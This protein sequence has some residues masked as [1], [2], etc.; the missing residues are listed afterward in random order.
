MTISINKEILLQKL[1]F[2]S[3]FTSSKLSSLTALQGILLKNDGEHLHIYTTNL[4]Y[5][6]HTK[7]KTEERQPFT[8]VLEPKKI[9]EYLSLLSAGKIE[10]EIGDRTVTITQDKTR[11]EFPII[12]STD[13]PF[14]PLIEEKPLKMKSQF[15]IKN[16]PLVLFS[17]S[18]DDTRPVLTGIN[19]VTQEDE[20]LIVA[21]DGFRLSLL[22][23]KKE[24]DFPSI[25]IPSHF[26]SEIVSLLKE[27]EDFAFNHSI[28]EKIVRF[29]IGE[30]ELYSRLIEGDY[31]PFSRVIPS[32]QKTKII[33]D[34]DEL[35]KNIKLASI[36]AREFSNIVIL[37]ASKEGLHIFP[38][39]DNKKTNVAYQEINIEGEDQRVAFNYRFL[40]D[41]LN[42][43][44]TKKVIIEL[45]RSDAPAVF[46]TEKNPNY[47]HII[48]PVRIQE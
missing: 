4:N 21:T 43:L 48:M 20:M 22:R 34:K 40:I 29:Q 42:H 28:K 18:T 36:F 38:K 27:E 30:H 16:L 33:A 3:K 39:L 1:I 24:I 8:M 19:F 46:K 7:I 6:Y 41:L 37:Q 32:E 45:L 5:F 35:I 25:I 13:F 26:L 11:G 10:I 12:I 17:A 31:P 15:F 47:L 9:I 2:A 44:D 14:P 23:E